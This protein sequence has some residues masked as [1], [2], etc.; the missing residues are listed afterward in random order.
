MQSFYIP[1]LVSFLYS[2]SQQ[3][4]K[5]TMTESQSTRQSA[6]LAQVAPSNALDNLFDA[7][8][9]KKKAKTQPK[10]RLVITEKRQTRSGGSL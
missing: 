4:V 6:R 2:I 3:G 9:S 10:A 1:L 8:P 7:L 5:R